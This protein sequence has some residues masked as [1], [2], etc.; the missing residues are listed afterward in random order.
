MRFLSLSFCLLVASAAT[1]SSGELRIGNG[2]VAVHLNEESGI[3][4]LSFLRPGWTFRGSLGSPARNAEVRR[5][6]DRLGSF[7]EIRFVWS[8]PASLSG[9]IR[10]YES[11]NAIL[12]T[13]TTRNSLRAPLPSFP[14]LEGIPSSLHLLTFSEREFGAPPLF[15]TV[16][17][18]AGTPEGVHSGPVVM[19][20]DHAATCIVS[21]E[22]D[23]LVAAVTEAGVGKLASGL[24]PSLDGMPAGYAYGTLVVFARGVNRAWEQWGEYLTERY[25]KKRPSNDAD[26]GLRYL[27]YWT[28]NGASYYYNYDTTKGYEGT[29]L[30]EI[31]HLDSVGIPIR[32]LQ[33]DSWWYRKGFTPPDGRPPDRNES[34]NPA[35]PA[36]EWNRYGGLLDYVPSPALFPNGLT[37]FRDSV[38]IPLVTHNRWIE[39]DSPYHQR[40]R[41]SGL[42][43]VDERWWDHI[44]G[45]IAGW[46]VV[47]YEQ[48]WLSM[49]YRYS[50]QFATTTW[51][52]KRFLDE[53][54]AA[55]RRHGLTMQYCM[56]LPRFYLAGGARYENLTTIRV[57]GDRF[58]RP[59]W[60]EFL[61]GSRLAS[62]LGV[63][64]W[65]DVFMSAERENLLLA[66]LSAGMV[67][68]G[69]AYGSE[70]PAN[71]SCA[72]RPDGVIVKPDCALVPTDATVLADARGETVARSACSRSYT[73]RGRGQDTVVY[74]FSYNEFNDSVR[75]VSRPVDLGFHGE[76]YRYEFDSGVGER[77]R[78]TASLPGLPPGGSS[79]AVLVPLDRHG[80]AL[81]GDPG[82][83]VTRGRQRV[84]EIKDEPHGI[85]VAVMLAES[86]RRFS[87]CGY[88]RSRPAVTAS[89]SHVLQVGYQPS[90]G[91]FTAEFGIDVDTPTRRIAGDLVRTSTVTINLEG[92]PG[93]P[94]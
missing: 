2:T 94:Q 91:A 79:Y 50:P 45:A 86:E 48:D 24:L 20:D 38:G 30:A 58:E 22:S 57:S 71:I 43:A 28:D 23:F 61:Y 69:D 35:L 84:R 12:F 44:T 18:R 7:N 47:T 10:L 27:G 19:F 60:K 3:Y 92:V 31:R 54:A 49:I 15:G 13:E 46:G 16:G 53:M 89:G 88:A 4:R 80:I 82:K 70:H 67:G 52:G 33:L 66:T 42:G 73:R 6:N 76:V 32:Y 34:K 83:F 78:S 9:S 29:L 21:P 26:I 63:W 56:A 72:V 1:V 40:Y 90:S 74:L 17:D 65:V 37:A 77:I 81:V 75:V 62:A 93:N 55:C 41:I 5:G 39:G 87:L 25:G 64:P 51:A 36:G 11:R 59:K 14:A 68:I 8:N 85:T